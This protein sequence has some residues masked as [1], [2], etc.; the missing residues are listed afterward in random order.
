M[1]SLTP[2]PKIAPVDEGSPLR[3]PDN[4]PKE[5]LI[6]TPPTFSIDENMRQVISVLNKQQD[7]GK[8]RISEF[9]RC[10]PPS[11]QQEGWSLAQIDQALEERIRIQALKDNPSPM[12]GLSILCCKGIIHDLEIV[13]FMYYDLPN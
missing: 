5:P 11:K 8:K 10:E 3:K 12:L 7:K 2:S 13:P 6:L 1:A 9:Y 4:I